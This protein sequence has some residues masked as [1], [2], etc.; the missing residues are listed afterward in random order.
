MNNI[1]N[2][3]HLKIAFLMVNGKSNYKK[4]LWVELSIG[5]ILKYTSPYYDYKI[6]LWNHDY[7]NPLVID[8][9][10]SVKNHVEVLSEKNFNLSNW[11][12]FKHGIPPNKRNYFSGGFHVHR[13][14]LQILY[15]YVTRRYDVEI[16]FTFDTDAWPIR[17]NWEV[18][19]IYRMERDIVLTGIWRDELEVIRPPHIHPSCLGIKNDTIKKLNL[20]FDHEAIPPKEDTLTHFTHITENKYNDHA[21]LPLRRSNAKEYHSVFNGIYGGIL[22]HHHLGSRYQEGK[23]TMV[24]TAGWK[25][26]GE[27]SEKNKFILDATTA[28]IFECPSDFISDLAYGE[29]AFDYKLYDYYLKNRCDESYSRLFEKAKE[30]RKKSLQEA[31]YI[32]GLICKYFAFNKEFLKFYAEVCEE[33]GHK[34]EADSYNNITNSKEFESK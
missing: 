8:Y 27:S 1:K 22:Y 30:K 34:T 33:I 23:S 2:N 11:T 4:R 5:N 19:L 17:N 3:K 12:G 24:V 7:K 26:R 10:S 25:E 28:M 16:I 13:A 20:R 9:L 15:E 14:P 32:S 21:I 29:K 18:P 6:F 31:Y